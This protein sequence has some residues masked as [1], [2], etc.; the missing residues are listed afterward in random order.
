MWARERVRQARCA[1]CLAGFVLKTNSPSCG[2]SD[3]GVWR[4]GESVPTAVGR[5]RFT[6]VL[7][8]TLP[9]LPV[10]DEEELRD[11][12]ARETFLGRVRAYHEAAYPPG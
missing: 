11:A 3:V 6:E 4:P 12:S 7:V 10:A 1:G 8:S 2:P 9:T 5:G